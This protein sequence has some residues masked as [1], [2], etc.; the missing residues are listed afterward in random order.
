[1]YGTALGWYGKEMVKIDD[2]TNVDERR[3]NLYLPP[4]WV[5]Y[6]NKGYTL[7]NDYNKVNK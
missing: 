7:P 1:L 6:Q 4:L 2:L 5:D 3:Y